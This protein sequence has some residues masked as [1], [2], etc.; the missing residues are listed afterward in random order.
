MSSI[1][2]LKVVADEWAEQAKDAARNA[3]IRAHFDHVGAHDLIRMWETGKNLHGLFLSR[4][5]GQALVER[6]CAVFGQLPPDDDSGEA[7]TEEPAATEPEPP[8]D[9]TMLRAKDVVRIT[10]V[11]LATVNRMVLDGRFPKPM[12]L[13]P[14]R[15]GWPARDVRL[16]LEER[17]VAR[18]KVRS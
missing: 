3:A 8:A 7:T 18:R 5:E 14:R 17:D 9:D 16:W 15:K 1:A 13:S 12:R 4:F 11:S 10:G 6:W 2:K